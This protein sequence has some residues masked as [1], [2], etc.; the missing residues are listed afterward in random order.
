[1]VKKE[2][3]REIKLLDRALRALRDKLKKKL[4]EEEL[5]DTKKESVYIELQKIRANI[6]IISGE[7]GTPIQENI[8]GDKI[9][10]S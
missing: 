8:P 6:D 1:M 7:L 2:I 9:D 10:R 4:T 3:E 5:D